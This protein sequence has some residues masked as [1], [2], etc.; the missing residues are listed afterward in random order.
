[1][2][3]T[4]DMLSGK[5]FPE[6]SPATAAMISSPSS[7]R[8]QKLPT[9]TYMSLDL[10]VKG[11]PIDLL[12]NMLEPSWETG[13]PSHGEPWTLNTGEYPSVAA[14]STLSQILVPNAPE[15]YYLSARACKGILNHAERRGK[16][17][18]KMLREALEE[19]VALDA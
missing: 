9:P 13:I 14:E 17:L 8:L 10:R 7:G 11:I 6:H 19:V 16:E 5:T 1:M 3:N 15:K 18:P 12:G 4:R 2:E